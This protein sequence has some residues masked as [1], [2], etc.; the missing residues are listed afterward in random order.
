MRTWHVAERP[1]EPVLLAAQYQPLMLVLG[2]VTVLLL[3]VVLLAVL[4]HRHS[5]Y[6]VTS[7]VDSDV[8]GGEAAKTHSGITL[9]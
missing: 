1:D 4:W 2:G 7:L 6:G 5:R 8:T 3:L 9:R